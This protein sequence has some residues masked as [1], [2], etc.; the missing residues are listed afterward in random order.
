MGSG[1][2]SRGSNRSGSK[3]SP[4]SGFS[5]LRGYKFRVLKS[6]HLHVLEDAADHEQHST[7][8]AI[9]PCLPER[10]TPPQR[11]GFRIPTDPSMQSMEEVPF[12]RGP[13][14][15]ALLKKNE[16][17][18]ES[19]FEEAPLEREEFLVVLPVSTRH[20]SKVSL[21]TSPSPRSKKSINLLA[22]SEQ[23]QDAE[24]RQTVVFL[25]WDDTL[26]PTSWLHKLGIIGNSSM[27]NCEKWLYYFENL[28]REQPEV[29]ANLEKLDEAACSLL[30]AVCKV[31]SWTCILTNARLG[32]VTESASCFMPKVHAFLQGPD[33]PEVVY[34]QEIVRRYRLE[35]ASVGPRSRI[36][37]MF[38]SEAEEMLAQAKTAAMYIEVKRFVSQL[39]FERKQICLSNLVSIGD[40]HA[41]RFAIQEVA[42]SSRHVHNDLITKIIKL[43]D[44]PDE[45]QV[46][47]QLQTL[48]MYLDDIVQAAYDLDVSF[49]GASGEEGLVQAL[50][51]PIVK[52]PSDMRYTDCDAFEGG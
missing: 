13:S 36:T 1:V 32:W 41:E 33:A 35:A 5:A 38:P 16:E 8:G 7:P 20:S 51:P 46:E 15:Q 48:M 43:R 29:V 44:H 23:E 27:E 31:S 14:M 37:A 9:A 39:V 34:A 50:R 40:G 49:D 45:V 3:A 4:R 24:L 2:S 25:D 30:Q 52:L 26:C 19:S 12:G 18:L 17:S 28:M 22:C 11:R 10:A 42:F 6:L 47:N 21:A